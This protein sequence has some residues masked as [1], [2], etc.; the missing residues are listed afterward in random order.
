MHHAISFQEVEQSDV[1]RFNV[2][3]YDALKVVEN[4]VNDTEIPTITA[5]NGRAPGA[6]AAVSQSPVTPAGPNGACSGGSSSQHVNF[7]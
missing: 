4:F 5:I 3:I 2:Q 1:Q 7:L 6:S